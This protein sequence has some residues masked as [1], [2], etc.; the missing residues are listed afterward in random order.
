MDFVQSI[1]SVTKNLR[2][3]RN[4]SEQIGPNTYMTHM[5][6]SISERLYSKTCLKRLLNGLKKM[7]F[8]YFLF[9]TGGLLMQVN[10][11]E[12]CA[13]VGLKGWSLNT[14]G[15]KGRFDCTLTLYL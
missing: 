14:G 11:S 15:V 13:F 2:S 9:R 1:H 10:Y 12:K 3:V 5:I 6:C 7:L 8:F 4:C